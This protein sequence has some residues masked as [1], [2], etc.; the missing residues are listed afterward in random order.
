MDILE[1][2]NAALGSPAIRQASAWLGESEENTRAAVRSVGPVLMAGVLQRAGTPA[3][4]SEIFRQVTGDR[5]DSGIA[6]RLVGLFGNRGSFESLQTTGESLTGMLFGE[7]TGN[8]ANAISQVSGV[9][10][11][12]AMTLLSMGVPLLFGTLKKYVTQNNLDASAFSSLLS[13]QQR[14]LERH[15][16]DNRI[17]GALGF[18]ST[19]ELLGS[20]PAVGAP[21]SAAHRASPMNG[22]DRSWLP[23]A[24]AAAVA[25][26]GVMFFVS[27]TA[28]YQ[29]TPSGAVRVG[30]VADSAGN[31]PTSV[32]FESGDANIDQED[33]LRIASVAQSARSADRP[34]AITGYTDRTGDESRNQELANDRAMAVRDALLSEGV[35]ESQIVMDPLRPVTGSGSDDE[36]RRVD[37]DM[38]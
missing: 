15:L 16:L 10:P 20:L 14:T 31:V 11:N 26:L 6:G 25:V 32:Y 33:R 2:F 24:T 9:Q 23:W 35:A 19:A 3:G 22:R 38:R 17:A 5:I 7:R 37:I 13:R 21:Q 18:G 12:S 27:R 8:V 28:E 36:A 4:V 30:E 29:E 34:L 1:V